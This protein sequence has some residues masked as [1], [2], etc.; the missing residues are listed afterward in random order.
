VVEVTVADDDVL[1]LRG[2]EAHLF[3]S[4]DDFILDRVIE[5]RIDDDDPVR[6]RHRPRGIFGLSQ[7]IKVVEDLDR[8]GMPLFA[9]RRL[10]RAGSS[11]ASRCGAARAS[12]RNCGSALCG[13]SRRAFRAERVEQLG[14]FLRAKIPCDRAMGCRSIGRLSGCQ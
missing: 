4:A 10:R 1:D 11:T 8:L 13:T 3:Q 14:P 12:C 7:E 5:D 6:R 9:G 2:I